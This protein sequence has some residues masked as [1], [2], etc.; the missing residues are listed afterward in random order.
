MIPASIEADR[1]SG[2]LTIEWSDG[3]HSVYSAEQLRWACPCA[4][5]HGEWGRPGRLAVEEALPAEEMQLIDIWAVGHYALSPVWGSGHAQGIFSFDYL[6][7][8][9]RCDQCS[10]ARS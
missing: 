7:S 2:S 8:I 10:G 9:C 4:E 3:H 5:C 1:A 6:R